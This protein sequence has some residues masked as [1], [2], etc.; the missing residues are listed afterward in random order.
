MGPTSW[1]AV[2]IVLAAGTPIQKLVSGN[3]ETH[4][5]C[6][7]QAVQILKKD[8][9]GE[10]ARITNNYLEVINRGVLWADRGW[11]NF[12][13][14]LDPVAGLGLGPWPDARLECRS[15]FDRALLYWRKGNKKKSFFF[16]G[17]A[18]HLVQDLCVP[19]H[20]RGIAFCG[21]KE[22]E[23]WAEENYMDFIVNAEGKYNVGSS[24]GDW[25]ESNAKISRCYF[26]YVSSM[27][28]LTS[29]RMATG[30]LLPVAQRSTAGFFSFFLDCAYSKDNISY[31]I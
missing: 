22:Y 19:H 29:F 10:Y 21:H 1:S 31:S 12:A 25:V 2:K 15:L 9:K 14:Y 23:K 17:A 27:G 20:A 16:L 24:P 5:F 13:H 6:N 8:G 4:I 18:A 28:S 26:P 7:H 11:K 30:V 3:G